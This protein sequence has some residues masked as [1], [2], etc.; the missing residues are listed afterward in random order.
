MSS[1]RNATD[2]AIEDMRQQI[3]ALELAIAHLERQKTEKEARKA[4]RA[5]PKGQ[6]E[7]Q[8]VAEQG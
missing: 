8:D 6:P 5:E 4:Q 3:K 1:K 2:R 7:L